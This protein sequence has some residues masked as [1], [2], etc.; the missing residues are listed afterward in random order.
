M[1]KKG[2]VKTGSKVFGNIWN[3]A[4][5]SVFTVVGHVSRLALSN[6]PNY[7]G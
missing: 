1:I 4:Q 5:C 7:Y 2:G 6:H 3:R